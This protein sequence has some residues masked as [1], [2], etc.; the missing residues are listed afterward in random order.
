MNMKKIWT[1]FGCFVAGGVVLGVMYLIGVGVAAV[2]GPSS[3]G[4]A[5]GVMMT[6]IVVGWVGAIFFYVLGFANAVA[7]GVSEGHDTIVGELRALRRAVDGGGFSSA[8]GDDGLAE[9]RPAHHDTHGVADDSAIDALASLTD[10]GHQPITDPPAPAPTPPPRPAAPATA[11]KPPPVKVKVLKFN[12]IKC[13]AH[14]A[15]PIEHA[16]KRAKC[17]KCGEVNDVPIG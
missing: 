13:E 3:P 2:I 11:T 7:A 17:K 10:T 9:M 12:C 8:A 5:V 6:F 15:A 14:L 4:L 16:G 1:A